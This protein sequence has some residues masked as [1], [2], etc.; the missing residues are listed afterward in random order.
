M[1]VGFAALTLSLF[2]SLMR[3]LGI[4]D[5]SPW[6][7]LIGGM[8]SLVLAFSIYLTQRIARTDRD[9]A[10][11]LEEV[12]ELTA[13]TLEHE[14]SARE[15]EIAK[16]VL[17]AD[18]LRKTVELEEAR[19]LQMAMLPS[20]LP[21]IPGFEMAVH[22]A[23]ASEVGGDYYDFLR[24]DEGGWTVVLGDATGHG[25]HAGMVVGVAKS[26]LW[27]ANGVGDLELMLQRID[28]GLGSLQ[29]R[30]ASMSLVLVRLIDN[31]LR[32]ASAGMPPVLVRRSSS[33]EVDEIL[34][35]G[36]PLGTLL[37]RRSTAGPSSS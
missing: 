20:S 28:A 29:E 1:A 5:V 10:R 7:L 33:G 3:S 17:E 8:G 24:D 15:Q 9:L 32:I 26:L 19:Q 25:L 35:P 18:N 2:G 6:P 31:G 34:L 23:T 13:R 22:V 36:V 11:R 21:R 4:L 16:R 37:K 27:A 30:R 14:R 12:Q